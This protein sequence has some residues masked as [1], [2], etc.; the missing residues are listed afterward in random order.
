MKNANP[1][2]RLRTSQRPEHFHHRVRQ[3]LR[4]FIACRLSLN[5]KETQH[6]PRI[7]IAGILVALQFT[8]A[9]AQKATDGR[10]D[11]RAEILWDRWGVPHI[12]AKDADSAFRAF[13]WAQMHSH[14]NLLLRGIAKARGRGAEYFG[15]DLLISDEGAR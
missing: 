13:G 4:C 6:M 10:D 14:G 3:K 9:L 7:L 15:K 12:Y 1:P 8:H 11:S 2:A 5:Q